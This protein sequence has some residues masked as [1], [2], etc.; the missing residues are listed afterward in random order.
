MLRKIRPIETIKL[1][2]ATLLSVLLLFFVFKYVLFYVIGW[3]TG[4]NLDWYNVYYP[5]IQ[6]ADPFTVWGYFNPPWLAWM[7]SPLG[8]LSAGDSHVLWIVIVLMLTVRCV[9]ALGG[10]W[11][12]ALLTIL[13]PG[14]FVA[15]VNGQVDVLVLLGIVTG[16][17][18]LVLIKPQVGGM[19]LV[20]DVLAN[21]RIDWFA[22]AFTAVCGVAFLL[23]MARPEAAGLRSTLTVTPWPWGIPVGLALFVWALLRRDKGLSVLSTFFLVPYI[24][25]S[26][27]FVYSAVGTSKYGRFVAILFFVAMWLRGLHWIT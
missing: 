1:F 17:W 12:G 21:R 10:G 19:S 26:S 14:F 5:A 6:Q 27:M 9:Y 3:N 2:F 7:L 13:S 22:V 25:A 23:F 16:S 24:S 15:V 8:K 11:F 18:L 4:L 20:Y